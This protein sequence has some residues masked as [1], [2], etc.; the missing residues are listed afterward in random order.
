MACVTGSKMVDYSY[1]SRPNAYASG[2]PREQQQPTL[3]FPAERFDLTPYAIA[4]TP[5]N[6]N[7]QLSLPISGVSS[8]LSF[9]IKLTARDTEFLAAMLS[10]LPELK[11][12]VTEWTQGHFLAMF[13]ERVDALQLVG[14][15]MWAPI[16]MT[17]HYAERQRQYQERFFSE[18]GMVAIGEELERGLDI[19]DRNGRPVTTLDANLGPGHY[20]LSRQL[21]IDAL[22]RLG[23]PYED[24]G[25]GAA[26]EGA[27]A[28]DAA[29]AGDAVI[30]GFAADAPPP[31]EFVQDPTFVPCVP[32][33]AIAITKLALKAAWKIEL[34]SNRH[35]RPDEVI[36]MLQSWV[37]AKEDDDFILEQ[38]KERDRV[39]WVTAKG[40]QKPYGLEACSK[41]LKEW[42]ER[43]RQED[44]GG[45]LM[46]V[47]SGACT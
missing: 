26:G 29:A 4:G 1:R 28:G 10:V 22:A 14:E 43:R 2:S 37:K 45:I 40:V 21:A 17:E 44:C 8:E 23:F 47:P 36:A 34:E 42:H 35:A 19:V 3:D 38:S 46:P 32:N 18:N 6:S 30:A 13:R 12:P 27:V 31:R 39:S 16:L 7:T 41:T 25:E 9:P 11:Y 15:E 5:L 33:K 20:F 24:A